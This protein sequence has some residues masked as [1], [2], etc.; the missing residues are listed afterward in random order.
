MHLSVCPVSPGFTAALVRSLHL[1]TVGIIARLAVLI[2]TR[3]AT[4]ILSRLVHVP[5]D[6]TAPMVHCYLSHVLVTQ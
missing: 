6:I 4:G 3:L 2:Q 5:K 1:V